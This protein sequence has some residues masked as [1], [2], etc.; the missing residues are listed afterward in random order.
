MKGNDMKN[1]MYFN[2]EGYPDPTAYAVIKK[3]TNIEKKVSLLICVLKAII[4]LSGFELIG[5]I[6]IRDRKSGRLFR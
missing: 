3:E 2:S 1:S 4:D 5:R 6:E